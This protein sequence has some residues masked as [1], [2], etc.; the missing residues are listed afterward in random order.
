MTDSPSPQPQAHDPYGLLAE[1]L[2]SFAQAAR[3]IPPSR[4]GRPVSPSC[5]W[6]WHRSGVKLPDGRVVRLEALK[7]INRFLTSVQAVHRFIRAQQPEAGPAPGPREPARMTRTP[8]RRQRDSE[9]ALE[10]LRAR[11]T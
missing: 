10:Q 4:R 1:T 11:R 2:I 7:L 3:L 6:R 8:G 5:V 9:H